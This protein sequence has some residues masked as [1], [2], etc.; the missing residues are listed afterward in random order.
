MSFKSKIYSMFG[1]CEHE[2]T[3][4]KIIEEGEITY[5]KSNVGNY[6]IQRRSCN[7]CGKSE[8][9]LVKSTV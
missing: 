8:N 9:D 1:W 2:W 6:F 4:W 5:M 7:K 3:A